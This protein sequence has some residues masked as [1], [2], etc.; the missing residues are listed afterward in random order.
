MSSNTMVHQ[1]A[2]VTAV[3]ESLL[4]LEAEV[5]AVARRAC[6]ALM[7]VERE[8]G[9]LD[10]FNADALW[11]NSGAAGLVEALDRLVHYLDAARFESP[12]DIRQWFGI[13]TLS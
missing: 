11:E 5:K 4:D 2:E 8:T 10:V 1:W 13:P 9:G 12:P 7:A 6:E 3:T